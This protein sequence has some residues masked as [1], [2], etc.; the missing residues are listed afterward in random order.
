M[1]NGVI[2]HLDEA[3]GSDEEGEHKGIEGQQEAADERGK[4]EEQA[5]DEEGELV[6]DVGEG[7]SVDRRD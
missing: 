5:A 7:D 1:N 2:C 4:V 6:D 3:E